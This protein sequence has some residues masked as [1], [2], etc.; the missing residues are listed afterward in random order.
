ML[1]ILIPQQ[2]LV[3]FQCL[4]R[5]QL[6]ITYLSHYQTP[7]GNSFQITWTKTDQESVKRFWNP[8]LAIP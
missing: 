7:E 2:V 1:S 5:Q 8:L 3:Y 6:F 4:K